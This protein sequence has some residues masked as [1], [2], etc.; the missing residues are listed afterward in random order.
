MG[1]KVNKT[2]V[3]T[4]NLWE[5][6]LYGILS[7]FVYLLSLLPLSVLYVIADLLY[8][9]LYR[10]AGYRKKL[11]RKNL[12]DSFPEKSKKEIIEIEKKFYHFIA[13]YVVE[14]IKLISISKKEMA[15]RVTFNNLEV[16]KDGIAKGQSCS[17]YIGHY[18]NWEWITSLGLHI[19]SKDAFVGQVYHVLESKVSDKLFLY[20]RSRM[21]TI[22]V[23]MS[24]I[25]RRRLECHREG[26]PMVMGYISDQ[27]PMWNNIHYWTP[28]L[29]H[30]TPVLTG[31]ETITKRFNDRALYFDV[32]R[33]RRGYYT[34]DIKLIVA[35]SKDVP[36]WE[37]TESYFRMLEKT[38]QRQPEFWLWTHNRW[39]RTREEFNRNWVEKDGKVKYIGD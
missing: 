22:C 19:D 39:K 37:I 32:S 29:N 6:T 9:V 23:A 2:T 11:A 38:I 20:I 10:C 34:I 5:K 24:E 25:L 12:T 14:T 26:K 13:D 1:K 3:Y 4:L 30:D 7:S 31:A 17:I 8:F 21:D 36:D 28:F 15:R 18:C 35:D 33:P 16:I 27:V